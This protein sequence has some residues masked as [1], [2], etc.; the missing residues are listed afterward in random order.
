VLDFGGERLAVGH[1]DGHS[2]APGIGNPVIKRLV[3]GDVD[4]SGEGKHVLTHRIHLEGIA[5]RG[6]VNEQGADAQWNRRLRFQAIPWAVRT[7]PDRCFAVRLDEDAVN[8]LGIDA[9]FLPKV[10]DRVLS[11]VGKPAGGVAL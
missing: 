6:P 8:R 10:C 4:S 1:L 2:R 9:M 11:R 3:D 5:A 7:V